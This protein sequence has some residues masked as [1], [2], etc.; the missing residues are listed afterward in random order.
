MR[1]IG[2]IF[3]FGLRNVRSTLGVKS[4]SLF[5]TIVCHWIAWFIACS[6]HVFRFVGA[7]EAGA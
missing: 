4:K 2:G 5:E 1:Y 3:L 6:V 7:L